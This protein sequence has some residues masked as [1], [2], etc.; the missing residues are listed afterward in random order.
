MDF[1]SP[2]VHPALSD[3]PKSSPSSIDYSQGQLDPLNAW[4]QCNGRERIDIHKLKHQQPNL[5]KQLEKVQEILER[6]SGVPTG[7]K[8]CLQSDSVE[9]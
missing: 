2:S 8:S 9:S 4:L 5:V 3:Q 1:S 7:T 6:F